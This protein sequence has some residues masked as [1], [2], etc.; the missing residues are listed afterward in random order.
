MVQ[1]GTLSP[2]S[3]IMFPDD[4]SVFCLSLLSQTGYY[5]SWKCVN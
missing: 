4:S 1:L 5:S 2:Q 3:L